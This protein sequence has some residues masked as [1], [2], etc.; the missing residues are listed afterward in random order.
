MAT[1]EHTINDVIARLL[2]GTRFAWRGDE[3]V[4]SETTGL[5]ADAGGLRP[6]IMVLEPYT[7]PVVIETELM[8]AA[9][10]EDEALARLGKEL[11]DSRRPVLSA[12]ALRLPERLRTLHASQLDA[13]IMALKDFEFAYLTPAP[14][15]TNTSGIQ[16]G[17]GWLAV[18]LICQS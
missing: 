9:S 10:V 16:R 5:L 2:R 8:P 15:R 14:T 3:V 17:A 13:E 7:S 12:I 11:S 4:L 6:D 18:Y 1:T